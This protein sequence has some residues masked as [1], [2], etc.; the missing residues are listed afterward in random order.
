VSD[1]KRD[2]VAEARAKVNQLA[3]VDCANAFTP[4][5]RD[6]GD[7]ERKYACSCVAAVDA[8]IAAA[9]RR[10]MER[11]AKH[12]ESMMIPCAPCCDAHT[13]GRAKYCNC[14]RA[15]ANEDLEGSA[16]EIRRVAEAV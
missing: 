4:Y 7:C 2:E 8:L 9:E 3:M 10:G 12:L 6:M 5:A 15:D 14:G 1:E 16:A 13:Y 11:A